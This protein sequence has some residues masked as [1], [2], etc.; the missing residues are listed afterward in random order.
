[1][2]LV[3]DGR[4][5]SQFQKRV[6]DFLVLYKSKIA[7]YDELVTG[8]IIFQNRMKGVGILSAENAVS[9]G[10]TGPAARGSGVSCDIRKN[11]LMPFMTNCNLMKFSKLQE[12]HLQGIWFGS[13]K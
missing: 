4:F 10:V 3:G 6:K 2:F 8:N 11:I 1:M 9:Y 12:I 7:E 5:A 13:E